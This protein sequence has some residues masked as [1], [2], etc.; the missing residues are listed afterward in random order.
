MDLKRSY[1]IICLLTCITVVIVLHAFE[2]LHATN[3]VSSFLICSNGTNVISYDD[4]LEVF[5][6]NSS[7]VEEWIN[8]TPGLIKDLK[9]CKQAVFNMN[10]TGYESFEYRKNILKRLIPPPEQFLAE[11]KNPCWY[12]SYTF[13]K[14][15]SFLHYTKRNKLPLSS[16]LTL[17][18]K[19]QI[20]NQSKGCNVCHTSILLDSLS[21]WILKVWHNCTLAVHYATSRSHA[22]L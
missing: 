16:D 13:P 22:P 17:L 20:V 4:D 5:E 6:S 11:F 21:C 19:K 10:T 12:A 14:E 15:F 1:H 3:F 7:K 2:S 9:V 18:T 8:L